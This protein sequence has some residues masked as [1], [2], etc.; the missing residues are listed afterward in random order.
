MLVFTFTLVNAIVGLP[1][2]FPFPWLLE[3]SHAI[4]KD[5]S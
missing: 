2:Y 5:K 3:L 1:Y 4:T